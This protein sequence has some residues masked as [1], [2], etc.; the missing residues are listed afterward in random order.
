MKD[1]IQK[2]LAMAKAGTVTDAQAAQLIEALGAQRVGDVV[3]DELG[4]FQVMLDPE[5]NEF[6]FIHG[7]TA[8]TA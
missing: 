7:P 2:I 1:Q 8:I 5:G 4:G 6:C 3:Y